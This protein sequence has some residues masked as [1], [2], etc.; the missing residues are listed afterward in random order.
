MRICCI[1]QSADV[2]TGTGRLVSSI[3]KSVQDI[4]SSVYFSSITTEN[5]ILPRNKIKTLYNLPQ[6]FRVV[7]NSDL[8]HAF[9]V[10]PYGFLA[11]IMGWL[12]HRPLLLT[13][14][15]SS[16]VKNLYRPHKL[17]LS[18]VAF[19]YASTVSAISSYV[20]NLVKEKIP[21]LNIEVINP[22]VDYKYWNSLRG[23]SPNILTGKKYILSVGTLKRRKGYDISL[24]VFAKLTTQVPDLYYVIVA[25]VSEE[26][27]YW[28]E[29]KNIIQDLGISEKVIILSGLTDGALKGVYEQAELF[30]LLSR[31]DK[32]DVEGFGLVFLE[33]AACG[34]PIIS[35]LNTGATD[36]VRDTYNGYLLNIKDEGAIVKAASDILSDSLLREGLSINSLSLAQEMDWHMSAKKYIRLYHEV[37]TT[38]T[39][40]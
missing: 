18:R 12:A 15:G 40:R 7:R 29:L 13:L 30:I 2:T 1:T 17:V 9:D 19:K 3:I 4:E 14:I 28:Q 34:L 27:P 5:L 23:S 6:I 37:L 39:K 22:G 20:Q 25:K 31:N 35:C 21:S 26:S 36:A 11:A 32:K 33:A 38:K 16:S 24:K 10:Y 8:V